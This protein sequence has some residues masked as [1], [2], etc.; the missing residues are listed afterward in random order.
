MVDAWGD[1][2]ISIPLVQK[3]RQVSGIWVFQRMSDIAQSAPQV[4][5]INV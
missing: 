5:R 2:V 3:I 4:L 1:A